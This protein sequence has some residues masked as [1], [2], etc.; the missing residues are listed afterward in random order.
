MVEKPFG[1]D[2]DSAVDLQA[3]LTKN[4]KESQIYRIDH[5]LGKSALQNIMLQRFTNTILEP[6]WNNQ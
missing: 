6:I 3:A 5:Y 1:T 2:L 4:L